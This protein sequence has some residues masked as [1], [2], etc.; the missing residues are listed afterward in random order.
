MSVIA[1]YRIQSPKLFVSDALQHVPKME[2]E[3]AQEVRAEP[4]R[5]YLL[6]WAR[7]GDFERFEGALESDETVTDIERYS[8]AGDSILYRMRFTDAVEI[9]AH[10]LWVEIGVKPI[11]I[12]YTDGWWENRIRLSDRTDLSTIEE[13]FVERGV[14]F[15]LQRVYTDNQGPGTRVELTDQQREVLSVA[16]EMGYFEIPRQITM[17][18]IA[19]ELGISSQAVSERLRR[20][21]RQLI[22]ESL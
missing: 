13:W 21:H 22:R 3:I 1:E 14:E 11:D 8:Q 16:L 12:F 4:D 5:P 20:G 10:S 2:L 18:D 9:V 17:S 15:D 19:D 7:S 6:I